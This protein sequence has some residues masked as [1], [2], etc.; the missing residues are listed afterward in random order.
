MVNKVTLIGNLG[1]DPEIKFSNSGTAVCNFSLA[2]SYKS[3]DRET[4]TEW[5]NCVAFGRT[6]EVCG[7]YLK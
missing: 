5:H 1:R 3:K 7:E 2:T 4:Q 6:G